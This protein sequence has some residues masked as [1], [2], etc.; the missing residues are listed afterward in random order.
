MGLF[1]DEPTKRTLGIR[2][3][4]ILYRNAGGKCQNPAC[5]KKIEFDEMQSGHKIAAARG[6]RATLKNSVCLCYRC[7]KL[8]GT[9]SWSAFLKKQGIKD[10]RSE[11]KDD[12]RRL[13]IPKLK[14][15]AQKHKVKVKRRVQENLFDS[16]IAPPSKEQYVNALSKALIGKDIGSE[17]KDM[18]KIEKKKKRRRSSGFWD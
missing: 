9:D 14:Y 12:L 2:D 10:G 16:Y 1:D 7:N 15:L 3:K 18:P 8:Q 17:L 13:S 4:Q 5:K 6:G 11:V